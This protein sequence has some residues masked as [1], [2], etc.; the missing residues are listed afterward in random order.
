M[1]AAKQ[2]PADPH[3]LC[4]AEHRARTAK[5]R[6]ETR[7]VSTC[8]RWGWGQ[9]GTD[10]NP[11]SCPRSAR[12]TS[13]SSTISRISTLPSTSKS[14][15]ELPEKSTPPRAATVSRR[16][17]MRFMVVSD[18]S[19]MDGKNGGPAQDRLRTATVVFL[20]NAHFL[21]HRVE[22][23]VGLVVF[24]VAHQKRQTAEEEKDRNPQLDQRQVHAFGNIGGHPHAGRTQNERRSEHAEHD[25]PDGP[26]RGKGQHQGGVFGVIH[27]SLRCACHVFLSNVHFECPA[28]K[29]HPARFLPGPQGSS[30][31]TKR[32]KWGSAGEIRRQVVNG[33]GSWVSR[34]LPPRPERV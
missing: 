32:P 7:A 28:T 19:A 8:L 15:T 9:P 6:P 16:C 24:V 22:I 30:W 31:L 11:P 12:R 34:V 17:S 26:I 10:A 2:L 5:N 13:A 14:E 29:D 4:I 18:L 21:P 23:G 33:S 20:Q 3:P 1:A 27:T 25:H